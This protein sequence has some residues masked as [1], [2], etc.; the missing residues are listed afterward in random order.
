LSIA[1]A[2]VR[3]TK[4]VQSDLA[5]APEGAEFY[6]KGR[7]Y[8]PVIL[9]ARA[10]EDQVRYEA[11]VS[12]PTTELIAWLKRGSPQVGGLVLV[13]AVEDLQKEWA[14]YPTASA[15]IRGFVFDAKTWELLWEDQAAK[16]EATEVWFAGA[17][18]AQVLA[19]T[20]VRLL[21]SLPC[22]GSSTVRSWPR[23]CP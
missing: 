23:T 10:P 18:H 5:S 22:A 12:N 9:P 17:V 2:D 8:T 6:L 20:T 13:L 16:T 1:V 21:Q 15:K 3:A 14:V 11:F 19:N 7:K 4:A